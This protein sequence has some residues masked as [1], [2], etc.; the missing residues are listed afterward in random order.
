MSIIVEGIAMIGLISISYLVGK[1]VWAMSDEKV[2]KGKNN[3]N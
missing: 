3:E 1:I 2:N